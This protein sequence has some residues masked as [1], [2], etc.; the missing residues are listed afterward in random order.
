MRRGERVVAAMA[1]ANSTP[2]RAVATDAV[3]VVVD[4]AADRRRQSR[5]RLELRAR[6]LEQARRRR[7]SARS[8]R[9]GARRR[10]PAACRAATP[11]GPRPAR[12]V[13]A[14][15]EA[16][17]LV[18]DLLQQLQAR[19]LARQQHRVRAA[20]E[21]DLLLA[22][23]ER[24]DRDARQ[25]EARASRRAPRPAGPCRRRSRAGSGAS[26]SC[27]RSRPRRRAGGA[28]SAASR[29]RRASGSRPGRPSWRMPKRR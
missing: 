15:R 5:D 25:V 22:L 3:Q 2:C 11:S 14:Q 20:G 29:P 6:G 7:R 4:R 27:G 23:G 10:R 28:R 16:V 9:A 8:A 21:V 13:P 1:S 24:D 26:R 17:R 18:A 19:R 12:A